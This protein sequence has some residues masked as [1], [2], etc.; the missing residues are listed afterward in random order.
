M[1]GTGKDPYKPPH[2]FITPHSL[3]RIEMDRLFYFMKEIANSKGQHRDVT[4]VTLSVRNDTIRNLLIPYM[5]NALNKVPKII[6]GIRR[7]TE[8]EEVVAHAKFT[9]APFDPYTQKWKNGFDHEIIGLTERI[10]FA[11]PQL[12]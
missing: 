6:L 12:D 2:L 9:N 11:P 4:S 10:K 5:Q 1:C 8:E 3:K 7:C